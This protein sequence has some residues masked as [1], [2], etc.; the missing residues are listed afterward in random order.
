MKD[1]VSEGLFSLAVGL[2]PYVV[3][4]V[5]CVYRD[6]DLA[7]EILNWDAQALMVFMWDRWNDLFRNELSFVE[8]SL[9]SELRDFR[10]RWA[11]Q[12]D[13]EESDV[14][15]VIDDIERLLKAVNSEESLVVR[16]LRIES[17]NRLWIKE[18]GDDARHRRFRLLWP[19]LLCGANSLAISCAIIYFMSA[20]WSWILSTL[21]ALGLMRVAFLQATRESRRG[22]GPHECSHCGRIIYTVECP[23][24]RPKHLERAGTDTDGPALRV[25]ET[26]SGFRIAKETPSARKSG[27]A[28]STNMAPGSIENGTSGVI[29]N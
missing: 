12:D 9:I 19:Y 22:P 16:S 8:R 26:S 1:P 24:C 10:N 28:G 18:L 15:R 4:R 20:P 27:T 23:Y 21:V 6:G 5:N 13:L 3:S 14:Y 17:L 11:H 25:S 7:A 2:R 29:Q